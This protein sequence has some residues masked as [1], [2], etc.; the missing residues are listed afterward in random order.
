VLTAQCPTSSTWISLLILG[1]SWS[2]TANPSKINRQVKLH[3]FYM[4]AA[5]EASQCYT[6]RKKQTYKSNQFRHFRMLMH[7]WVSFVHLDNKTNK[8]YQVPC[9]K[10]KRIHCLG[11]VVLDWGNETC[12]KRTS[13]PI[14]T[15]SDT[16]MLAWPRGPFLDGN[17]TCTGGGE[18][19]KPF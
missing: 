2:W 8:T 13:V 17:P 9:I 6:T 11:C 19:W 10:N 4:H 3:G 14:R 18:G 5:M 12:Q 16:P 1:L 7:R 15:K